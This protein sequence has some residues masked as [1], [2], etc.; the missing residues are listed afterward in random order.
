MTHTA[1]I[2][3]LTFLLGMVVGAL[4]VGFIVQRIAKMGRETRLTL[5]KERWKHR[6]EVW[7]AWN[8]DDDLSADPE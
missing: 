2:A 7:V 1:A 6:G 5:E 3:S 8:R 4:S